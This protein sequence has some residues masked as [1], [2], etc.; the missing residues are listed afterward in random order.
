MNCQKCL[1]KDCCFYYSHG[2]PELCHRNRTANMIIA[3]EF[4]G[5]LIEAQKYKPKKIIHNGPATIVFWTDG[6]KTVVKCATGTEPD[7]YNA[8]C[9][10]LAKKIYGTNSHLK[11]IIETTEKVIAPQKQHHQLKKGIKITS[12]N[13][14]IGDKVRLLDG[15]NLKNFAGGWEQ[16][17]KEDVGK[18]CTVSGVINTRDWHSTGICVHEEDEV[19]FSFWDIRALEKIN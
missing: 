3:D 14:H 5:E 12:D 8:F 6:S 16:E 11:R 1:I 17:M 4:A 15:S 7:M 18:V 19:H 10:A 9:A 2:F 13:L